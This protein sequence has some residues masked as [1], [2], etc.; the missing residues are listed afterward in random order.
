M[1]ALLFQATLLVMAV[2]TFS[3]LFASVY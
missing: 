1:N 3:V 2:V